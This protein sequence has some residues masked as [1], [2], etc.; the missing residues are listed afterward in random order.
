M[1]PIFA[2]IS[3]LENS[4][5]FLCGFTD[6]DL[7]FLHANPLFQKQFGLENENWKG[8]PFTD[9]VQS[10]QMEKFL[11]A[12]SECLNNPGKTICIEIQT[13]SATHENWFRW[14]VS[15]VVDDKNK[16]EGIRF[17]GTDITKQKKAEQKLLQQA[18]LLDN[19]SDAIISTDQN[20][21][22]KTWNLQAEM[23]FN[24]KNNKE[25]D[26]PL[27]EIHKIEIINDSKNN[28]K[29]LVHKNGFWQGNVLLEKT[30]GTKFYLSTTVNAI[31]D[32][33]GKINGFVAVIRNITG[34]KIDSEHGKSQLELLKEQPQFNTF[35]EHAPAL[36]WL[37]DEDGI[38]YYMNALFKNSFNLKEDIIGQN[39]FDCYPISMRANCIASDREVLIKNAG[40]ETFEELVGETGQRLCYQV[41][42]FPAGSHNNK[43]LIGGLAVNFTGQVND[44]M[45]IV[46]ERNQFQSFME[47]AP[48]LAWITDAEGVLHYMNSRFKKSFNYTDD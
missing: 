40:L 28:F 23:M 19:I 22:I 13:A 11:H 10:F 27:H 24:L 3:H 43:K 33:T 16:I 34:N 21:R 14:E 45:E 7:R 12:N 26:S 48:L 44:R 42:K 8:R 25:S 4:S 36:A 46:K 1:N 17:L 39:I 35:M 15:A 5:E 41:Y 20:L 29:R 32:R 2:D 31:K 47:N 37:N 38:L 6:T 9:V 30:N 18:F